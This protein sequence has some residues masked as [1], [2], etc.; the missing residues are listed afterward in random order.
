MKRN[1][2]LRLPDAQ[3]GVLTE[4]APITDDPADIL[5]VDLS[6]VD[7]SFPLLPAGLYDLVVDGVKVEPN[8]AGNGRNVVI[9]LKTTTDTTSVKGEA[10][11]KGFPITTYISLT[12]AEKYNEASI[13]RGLALF[14]Q[15]CGI[16]GQ[17][18][19]V[20]QYKDKIV[21]CKVTIRPA[22][23]EFEESNSIKFVPPGE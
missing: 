4:P 23:G 8:K 17:F 16:K 10:L 7:T 20:S 1:T 21:R 2:V 3:E 18:Q 13:K 15:A 6:G 5:S 9:A 22:K 11:N 14:Q 19:P 12:P